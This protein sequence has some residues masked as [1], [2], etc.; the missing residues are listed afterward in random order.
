MT[1]FWSKVPLLNEFHSEADVELRLVQPL[2]QALGY[3][4]DDIA[5]KHPVVFHEGRVGR[6]PEADFVCFWGLLRTRDNSLL[7]IEAKK[8]GESMEDA[9]K[10]GESYAQNLRAPLLLLTDGKTLELWQMQITSE[11]QCV[12]NIPVTSLASQQGNVERF[13]NKV[14]VYNYCKSLSFKTIVEAAADFG[15]YEKAELRRML[16]AE[17]SI[18]RTLRRAETT[19]Q[20]NSLETSRLLSDFSSGAIVIAASGYGKTTLCKDVFKQAIE[21]RWCGHHKS[22]PFDVPLPDLEQSGDSLVAF[23]R[24]RLSAHHS[25]VTATSFA[26]MLSDTG[27]TIF[28]DSF[29]RITAQFQKKVTV[30][31]TNLLRDYP[32]IQL[33]IFSRAAL[34]PNVSLP[35]L[36][37]EKLSDEQAL[38]LERVILSDGD[39]HNFSIIGMMSSTLRSLC[40]NP[41]LLRLTLEY[42]KRERDF[43]RKIEFLFQSWIDTVLE[44]EPSDPVSKLQRE[45]ALVALA[46]ATTTAPI[47]GAKAIAR[48]SDRGIP[49]AVLNELIQC[50]AVRMTGEVLELQHEGLADYLRAKALATANEA[51]LSHAITTLT[52]PPDSFFPVLLMAQL[53]SRNLQSALWKRLTSARI[54]IYLDALRYRFDVSDELSQMDLERL[55]QEYLHDLIDGIEVPLAGF[56]PEM[57][58]SV[59][60]MLT[61]VIDSTLA[62]TGY[63][64][65]Q[66][67]FIQYK[68]HAREPGEP[69]VI[70]GAPTFPG[71]IRGVN[72][73]LSRY[74]IDSARLLGMTLLQNTL[75][76]A[77][78]HLDIKGGPTWAAERLI[79]RVRY[80]VE[81]HGVAA[82]ITDDLD[83][84]YSLLKPSESIWIDD[85]SYFCKERFSIQSLLDDIAT[86]RVAGVTKLEPWWSNLGWDDD[87]LVVDEEIYRR[88]LDEEHR[89]VQKVYAEI[90]EAS[91]RGMKAEM[92]YFP[93]LPIRWKL[94]VHR[95][96][97]REGLSTIYFHWFPVESWQDAGADVSFSSAGPSAMPDWKEVQEALVKLGRPSTRIPSFGGW[98]M[99]F[100]YDGTM[101][102]GY[103]SGATSV[104]NEVCSWLEDDLKHLFEGLPSSDGAF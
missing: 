8:P 78:N 72:L 64:S 98:T 51:E 30:E 20:A 94:T 25:G 59:T 24:K 76:D 96:D 58:A 39:A 86:L 40:V 47:S 52:V 31:F 66:P 27:V 54:G 38:E 6:R 100:P 73:D 36:E 65:A 81:N 2:L 23:V 14:A 80:L 99:H 3:E 82:E 89:R 9:K 55:S 13:L 69:R 84:L 102:N 5:P 45:Q 75:Q 48:L 88:V 74:R 42:W 101:P 67:G 71:I 62:A 10:Q 33:F 95:R 32:R 12:L 34:K 79:G 50:N 60:N 44:T 35:L 83:K 17:P 87:A 4:S 70:A 11:S 57:R 41:L 37:L 53:P 92:I 97:R 15:G 61:G 68:L 46:E 90:V 91:F 29:D 77:I 63:A 56:F 28:C 85:G 22:L 26:T 7:V 93:L 18:V 104:T 103:F 19:L 49:A 16:R 21:E 43:P 1:D